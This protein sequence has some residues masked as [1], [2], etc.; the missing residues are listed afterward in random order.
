MMWVVDTCVLLDVALNDVTFALASAH[1]LDELREQGLCVCPV[2]LVEL[3]P[4]FKGKINHIH[5]FLDHVGVNYESNWQS[6][7]TENAIGAWANY[8]NARRARLAPKRPIADMMIGA[9]AQSRGGLIT[10]NPND[11]AMWFPKLPIVNPVLS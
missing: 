3:A 5:H 4:A 2:T 9:F 10:R 11:F 7:D 1:K 6:N 8:V